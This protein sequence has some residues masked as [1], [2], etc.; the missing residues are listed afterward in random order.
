[1]GSPLAGSVTL[2][3]QMDRRIMSGKTYH[4]G[5]T[6][7]RDQNPAFMLFVIVP[8]SHPPEKRLAVLPKS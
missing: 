4:V 7:C 8:N 3:T 2:L 6:K 5:V 1:M